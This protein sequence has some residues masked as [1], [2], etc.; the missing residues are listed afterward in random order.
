MHVQTLHLRHPHILELVFYTGQVASISPLVCSR[1]FSSPFRVRVNVHI[2][3]FRI[4]KPIG[5][6]GLEPT[7]FGL[8]VEEFNSAN[9]AFFTFVE[10]K[11]NEKVRYLLGNVRILDIST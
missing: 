6:P 3:C 4:E 11:L 2:D 8:N 1:C 7:S 9:K 5:W 10:K